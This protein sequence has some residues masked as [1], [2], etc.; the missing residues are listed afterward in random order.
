M[1]AIF[2]VAAFGQKQQGQSSI[3]FNLGY[4]FDSENVLLGL[5]YRYSITDEIR[6]NPGV[7][8]LI[9]KDGINAWMIDLNLN[10]LINLNEMVAFYPI[11]GLSLDFWK[12]DAKL[13]LGNFGKYGISENFNRF[14]VNL[15]LGIELYATEEMTLGIETKYNLV[16]DIDQAILALRVGYVF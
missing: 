14:G 11:A 12:L 2:S 4:A 8:H 15:G 6:I 10:Y 5:D 16:K 7:S 1:L 13:D 3:G 9:K